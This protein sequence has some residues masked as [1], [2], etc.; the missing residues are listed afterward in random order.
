MP[1]NTLKMRQFK[2]S[3]QKIPGKGTRTPRLAGGVLH[4]PQTPGVPQL[5]YS[6][7]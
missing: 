3:F 6:L 1:S 7:I 4:T 2:C 5:Q